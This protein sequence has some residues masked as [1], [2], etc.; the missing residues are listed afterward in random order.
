MILE[1]KKTVFADVLEQPIDYFTLHQIIYS[2]LSFYGYG[3]TLKAFEKITKIEG[4]DIELP[5]KDVFYHSDDEEE[6][7]Y[8]SFRFKPEEGSYYL[9]DKNELRGII[10]SIWSLFLKKQF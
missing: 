5:K 7:Y 9:E 10:F 8:E 6:K 3:D 1:E 2:Y 4:K